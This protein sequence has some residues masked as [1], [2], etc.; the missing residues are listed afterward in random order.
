M[1]AASLA[2]AGPRCRAWL[3][4]LAAC[5]AGQAAAADGGK[6]F[7]DV[8]W[9]DPATAAV[10]LAWRVEI[11]GVKK[12]GTRPGFPITVMLL[13]DCL[14]THAPAPLQ[15]HMVTRAQVKIAFALSPLIAIACLFCCTTDDP[16]EEELRRKKKYDFS[17]QGAE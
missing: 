3:L 6:S 7:F 17:L 9:S 8:D 14:A 2:G 5:L 12:T 16:E 1:A 4:V 10:E 11:G 13:G 15:Q